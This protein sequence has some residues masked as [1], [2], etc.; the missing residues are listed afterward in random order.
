MVS[1]VAAAGGAPAVN[2]RTPFGAPARTSPG[3]LAMP[4]STVGAAQNIVMPS[5]RMSRKMALGSTCRR[6]TWVMPRAV[7]IQTKVQP[8]T[9]NMGR[10]QR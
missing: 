8:L 3:A 1:M 5:S 2:S 9:W 10:V 6:H 4:I 7:L